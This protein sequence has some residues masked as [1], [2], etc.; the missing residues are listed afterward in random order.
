M[1]MKDGFTLVEIAIVVFIIGLLA[2]NLIM[3]MVAQTE[4]RQ[5]N[6]TRNTLEEIKEALLGFAVTNSG[7]LPCPASNP[8]TGREDLTFCSKEGYVPWADLG[9]GRYDGWSNPFRYRV[10]EEFTTSPIDYK[11]AFGITGTGSGLK[12]RT[13]RY[14]SDTAD[15]KHWLSV[16]SGDTRVIAIIFSCGKN[17][18]PDPTVPLPSILMAGYSNDANDIRNTQNTCDNPPGPGIPGKTYISN[19]IVRSNPVDEAM[20][21]DMLVWLSRTTWAN[22]LEAAQQ[23]PLL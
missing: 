5:L 15:E 4:R 22:R 13:L 16:K 17:G 19:D 6:L 18:R 8:A 12:V 3:P 21:D 1:K 14:S 7:R 9:V 11:Q 10:E 23:L 2:T 20:F